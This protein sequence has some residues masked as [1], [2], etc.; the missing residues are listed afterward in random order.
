MKYLSQDLLFSLKFIKYVAN[1]DVI[2]IIFDD[3][4]CH[5]SLPE[6][7]ILKIIITLVLHNLIR[8]KY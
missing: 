3:G 6:I 8:V 5:L 7:V 4:S 1:F 2:K